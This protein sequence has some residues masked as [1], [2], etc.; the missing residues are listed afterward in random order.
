MDNGIVTLASSF[1]GKNE[2]DQVKRWSESAK[3]HLMVDRPS[4]ARN[5]ACIMDIW[6]VLTITIA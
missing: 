5:C 2:V 1:C 4:C 6:E 3:K